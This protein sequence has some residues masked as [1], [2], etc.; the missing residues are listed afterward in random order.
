MKP[1]RG[2]G[3]P[4]YH[5]R[6]VDRALAILNELAQGST[7]L[8][9]VALSEKLRLHKSTVHRLL[10]VLRQNG[11]IER[12]PGGT[13]YRLGW[14]AFDLGMAAASQ[15]EIVERVKPFLV[16]LV[17][18]TEETCHFAVLRQ[19]WVVSLVQVDSQSNTRMPATVGRRIPLHC[20][21]V[22]KAILASLPPEQVARQLKGYAFIRHTSNTI[23]SEDR[24]LT[25]LRLV[26]SRGYAVDNEEYE[27]GLR[28]VAAPVY[29]PSGG[30]AGAIGVAGPTYRV[31]ASRL[32][33]LSR[34][35]RRIAA[36]LS[37]SLAGG[38]APYQAN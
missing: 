22:G 2:E 26:S 27:D 25:E 24:F 37:S 28:C 19:A 5:V 21:S 3:K 9:D 33:M 38:A 31:T 12:E 18:A 7:K 30:V 29:G 1:A 6:V 16:Q 13:K 36:A 10:A 8:G 35:A 11:F 4:G 14:R 32:P 23:V 17:E 15:L 20:T 34:E